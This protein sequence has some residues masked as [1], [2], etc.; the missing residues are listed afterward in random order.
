MCAD[1]FI[2]SAPEM[3]FS[4]TGSTCEIPICISASPAIPIYG[5][6][7]PSAFMPNT[8]LLSF[9]YLVKVGFSP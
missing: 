7:E 6:A 1:N 3:K 5:S 4:P 9:E 2:A 8:K